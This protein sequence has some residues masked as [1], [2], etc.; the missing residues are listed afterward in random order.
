MR[1]LS[2]RNPR[3]ASLERLSNRSRERAAQGAFVVD[4]PVLAA[5]AIAAGLTVRTLFIDVDL[6]DDPSIVRL[7]GQAAQAGAEVCTLDHTTFVRVTTPVTPQGV[8]MVVERPAP[9]PPVASTVDF[10]LVLDA[11][12]DPGNVGTLL[13][14]AAATGADGVYLTTG[15][16]DAFAPKTVRASAG[17]IFHVPVTTLCDPATLRD[18]LRAAKLDVVVTDVDAGTPHDEIDFTVP[19]AI[20][21]GNEARGVQS[22]LGT[23]PDRKAHIVMPGGIESLN[24]AMAGTVLCFEV[25]RQRRHRVRN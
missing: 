18:Q 3:V 24:V 11:V 23:K 20:V 4:G 2:A 14:V 1:P 17:A 10:V 12:G 6:C 13:R 15:C 9:A 25:V 16:A 22:E 5:D 8:A 19:T 21:L 7:A